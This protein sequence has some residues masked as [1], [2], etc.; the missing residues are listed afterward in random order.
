MFDQDQRAILLTLARE[1]IAIYLDTR[2]ITTPPPMEFLRSPGAAFVTLKID[3]ELRGCIGSIDASE[4]LGEAI[5]HSAIS[6]AFRDPRFPP[7]TQ[8]EFPLTRLEI[9]V[10]SE[11]E[12][13]TNP[14]EIVPGIHGLMITHQ[15]NR[16]LLLPQVATEY[17]W[18]RETFLSYTCRK[19]GLS[20]DAWKNPD[21]IIETFTAEI[22]TED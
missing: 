7:L 15:K 9:S 4:P 1:S 19:A 12:T 21:T 13:R 16:G 22:L 11:F 6:A 20:P 10:L 5:V 3:N 14:E 18:D 2:S 8:Q 17:D